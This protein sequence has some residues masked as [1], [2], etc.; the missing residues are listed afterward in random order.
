[1]ADVRVEKLIK[2][3]GEVIAVNNLSLEVKDKEFTVFLGPSGCGKTTTLRTIAGLEQPDSGNIY[4]DDILVN[5][6]TPADRDVA[7]VFQ[8]YALYPHKTVYDNMAFPLK[9]VKTPKDEIDK[10][11]REVS[12]ILRLDKL[13]SR[14]PEKLSGGE[15]Q[16]VALGRAMVR[17][18]KVFLMD[19]PLTNLDAKLRSEMRAELKRLQRDIGATTIYVT[20]D[21]LEAMSM[22]DKIAVINEGIVQQ[23]G[24][25][26]QVYDHPSSLFVAGFVGNPTM[27]LLE[28][29]Y[30]QENG[31]SFLIIGAN[32]FKMEISKAL[33]RKIQEN[34]SDSHLILGIRSEDIFVRNDAAEDTIRSEVYV[35]EPLGSENIIDLKIGE[36]IIKAKTLPTVYPDI[37]Q[38]VYMWFNKDRMHIF[39]KTT[40]K[41]IL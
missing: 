23:L 8:F 34:A 14:T 31:N 25:P 35:V 27:N 11:V 19:E 40:E 18:P 4:I 17:R 38:L 30:T 13:L 21:Q 1:M 9:A 33:G 20:H 37:G 32:D 2:R 41:A 36:N 26:A 6:L 7:F 28:C 15:M 16:R 29:I 3:F 39:D 10:R 5:D 12:A 22:G 24:T